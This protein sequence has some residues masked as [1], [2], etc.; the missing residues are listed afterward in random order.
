MWWISL[1]W[2]KLINTLLY[3]SKE[4]H[5]WGKAGQSWNRSNSGR[6]GWSEDRQFQLKTGE[7]NVSNF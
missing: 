7:L 6:E 5:Q 1:K 3:H 4:S 2:K